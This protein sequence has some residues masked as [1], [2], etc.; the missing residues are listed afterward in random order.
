M[1]NNAHEATVNMTTHTGTILRILCSS[2]H[3]QT[4]P[5]LKH[6][7]SILVTIFGRPFVKRFI[8]CYQTFVCPV[9]SVTLVYC[10]QMVGWIKMKLGMQVGVNPRHTVLDGD[11][12]PPPQKGAEHRPIFG[13]FLSSPNSWIK[14]PL[15]TEVGLGRD[16]HETSMDETETLAFRDRDVW[17]HQPRRDRDETFAGLESYVYCH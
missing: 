6:T 5:K 16:G 14:M 7:L 9:L 11:P 2:K 10:G 4:N 1:D 3:Y 12:A 13:T 17:P 15:G 8:L